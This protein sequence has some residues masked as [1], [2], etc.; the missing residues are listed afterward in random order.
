MDE[1]DPAV[2]AEL[3][4]LVDDLA[5]CEPASRPERDAIATLVNRLETLVDVLI[6]RGVLT[7][8]H[9]K[10]LQRVGVGA[11]RVRL[12]TVNDKHF[13]TS[14]DIDCA[15]R[16]PLCKARCCSLHVSLSRQDLE[17]GLR[18]DIDDPYV[19]ERGPDGYCCYLGQGGA[20]AVYE[21][22]PATCRTYD[23]R[24][25]PRIW[26]DFEARIPA[27]MPAELGPR[28]D[29]GDPDRP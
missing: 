27:P 14:P 10:V 28:P 5:R 1:P 21:N 26:V 22:R 16:I 3:E 20:C 7:A 12:S 4:A 11:P 2:A 18:W 17:D 29:F 23:C 9:R 15:S 6:S 8:G 24:Q 19:L 13:V 25:D